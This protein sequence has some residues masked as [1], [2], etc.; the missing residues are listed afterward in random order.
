MPRTPIDYSKTVMYKIQCTEKPELVYVGHTTDFIRRQ[1]EHRKVSRTTSSKSSHYKLYEMMRE[2]GGWELFKMVQIKEFPCKNKREAMSEEDKCMIELKAT[3]NTKSGVRRALTE[4]DIKAR[5]IKHSEYHKQNREERLQKQ[6]EYR[7]NNAEKIRAYEE[8][9]K[10]EMNRKQLIRYHDNK[11]LL[12]ESRKE[13]AKQ[14]REANQEKIRLYRELNREI[15][16]EKK[17][18]KRAEKKAL[19]Q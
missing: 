5:K 6:K 16:N 14:Y 3:L 13:Y 11:H 4:S 7:I 17:R 15:L 18:Q 10:D 2:N 9:N 1:C 19:S 8:A 12:N